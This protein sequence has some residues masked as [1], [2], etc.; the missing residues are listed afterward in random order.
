[1]LSFKDNTILSISCC[2]HS[3]L[4]FCQ[5]GRCASMN[6]TKVPGEMHGPLDFL[7]PEHSSGYSLL[8]LCDLT[9]PKFIWFLFLT[10][11]SYFKKVLY[12]RQLFYL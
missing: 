9:V 10:V 1:M 4:L 3:T 12:Y 7:L 6:L 2:G 8:S 5:R 11:I